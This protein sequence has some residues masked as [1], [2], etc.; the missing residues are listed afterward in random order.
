MEGSRY[1]TQSKKIIQDLKGKSLT[2][3]ERRE[4]A[5]ELATLIQKEARR[6]ISNKERRI[7]AQLARMMNDPSGK[8]FTI[9]MTDQCFRSSKVTRVADQLLYLLNKYGVP[10]YLSYDKQFQLHAFKWVANKI[11]SIAVP[12]TKRALRKETA[13]VVLPGEWS[14]L[15]KH[16]RKRRDEGIRINLNRLGEAILG[17]KEAEKRLE[18]YIEDLSKPEIEYIS[19]KISTLSSQLNLIDRE[20]TLNHLAQTLR[21]LYRAAQQYQYVQPTGMRTSKFVNLD[22]EEFRDLYLT[23]ELFKK[24]L[25][26]PEFLKYK[27]GIV[28]Q[29]YIP[30]SFLLQQELTVWALRRT[31]NGGAPIKIRIVKGANLAAEKVDASMHGWPLATYQTKLE[32]DGNFK[33]M[34]TYAA[35][36]EHAKSVHIGIGSHNLFDICYAIV[37]TAEKDIWPYMQFEM[38]EGMGAPLPRVV[39]ELTNDL[40]LYCPVADKEHFQNAVAYL[41]RRLDE[42]TSS[43]N[44]LRYLFSMIPGTKHWQAQANLFSYAC[45]T[46]QNVSINPKRNQN[47]FFPPQDPPLIS[48]FLNEADTDWSLPTNSKWAENIAK[49]WKNFSFEP[50]PLM[51]AGEMIHTNNPDLTAHGIAPSNPNKPLFTYSLA[52]SLQ[53]NQAIEAALKAYPKWRETSFQDRSLLLA[54]VAQ[55]F[56]TNR[57]KLIG[58][59]IAETGKTMA[60][61]DGEISEAIDFIEYYRRN[62]EKFGLFQDIS[63]SPKGIVV[64]IPPWNFPCSIPTG[65][66]VAALVTGNCVL[67]KPALEAVL[68][69]YTL[70]QIL[71]EAG[72]DPQ[73]LQFIP[74][75]DDPVASELVK[76]PRVSTIVLTGA[77]AT[78]KHLLKLRPGMNLVAETGGKNTLIITSLADRDLAIKD[79]MHSAFSHAGQKCSACSLAILEAEVYDDPLFRAQLCDAVASLPVGSPWNLSTRINPLIR[80]PNEHLLKGLTTLEEGEEWLLAPKQDP[81]NPHLWSPGIKIGV[82]KGSFTYTTELFGPVL[83]IMRAENLKHALELANGTSYGLTAGLHSLDEREQNYWKQHIQAG[84]C[85]INR[86]ITG[87]IVQ[88]QPFGG[89]KQSSFGPSIKAGGPHTLTQFM[90]AEQKN[91]PENHGQTPAFTAEIVEHLEKS[92][93]SQEQVTRWKAAIT[94]YQQSWTTYFSRD[95]DPSKILGQDN[96]LHYTPYPKMFFRIQ[97]ADD[98]VDGLLVMA[99]AHICGTPLEISGD[100]KQLGMLI[101]ADWIKHFSLLT[102]KIEAEENFIH[103]ISETQD[104]RIR[105]LSSSTPALL[106]MLAKNSFSLVVS[107]VLAKGY[108]ELIK[109]LREVA[110]SINYHRYGN[111]GDREFQV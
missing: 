64:V 109:Y 25:E 104:G 83:G 41:I 48:P 46:M 60:E 44:F 97:D 111:L 49:D 62:A 56:R 94:D 7:Q 92:G 55:A 17:E 3:E 88:R 18:K 59:M 26:E 58:V 12:L 20:G 61:A 33:R 110:F 103:R 66:I 69:G 102:L 14:T 8:L 82:T 38:L 15:S 74:C 101:Q 77:T 72:I 13:A 99:A 90:H 85:Y 42:N 80:P 9:H 21:K 24:V 57:G 36:P 79:L 89:C 68:V 28:L 91:L 98:Y 29:S 50:V 30:D 23:V 10:S 67:F 53:V 31:A 11:P 37:L 84:N 16:V 95:H 34:L 52:N 2:V 22:M 4:L 63:W 39:K 87:A 78:A 35:Q 70:A 106:E 100:Q 5:I 86:T 19:V 54:K 107:P 27:A 51:I 76:D 45:H 81:E 1:I 73:V 65:G 96:L 32:T 71:W 75:Q 40:L 93:F 43:E 105:L 108:L 47:R 6:T